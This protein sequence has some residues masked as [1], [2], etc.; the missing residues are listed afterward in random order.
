MSYNHP[1]IKSEPSTSTSIPAP[2]FPNQ[3][4]LAS[5]APPQAYAD[6]RLVSTGTGGYKFNVLKFNTPSTIDPRTLPPPVLFNRK[7]PRQAGRPP[8]PVVDPNELSTEMGADGQ[9]IPLVD[10]KPVLDIHGKP[11]LGRDGKIMYAT[12]KRGPAADLSLIAP[13]GGAV[14]NKKNL[15]KK[16][17]KQVHKVDQ[18]KMRLRREERYPWV[19]ESGLPSVGPSSSSG[20]VGGAKIEEQEEVQGDG[21][22]GSEGK[23]ADVWVGT[24]EDTSNQNYVMFVFEDDKDEFQVMDV[25][26]WYKFNQRPAYETLDM[27]QAE[28]LV[29]PTF[30]LLS[31]NPCFPFSPYNRLSRLTFPFVCGSI[32]CSSRKGQ[33]DWPMDDA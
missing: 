27:D 25:R 13:G 33:G 28:E 22:Q 14:N 8:P 16:K 9:L 24:M 17:T 12:G 1:I 10:L 3:K 23:E 6:Y 20:P 7:D 30:S 21:Q 15:F 29:S 5:A 4:P 11:M 2:R 19:L 32:V 31:R 18:E 26:R